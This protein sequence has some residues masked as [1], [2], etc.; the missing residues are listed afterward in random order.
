MSNSHLPE[1]RVAICFRRSVR[2]AR[3]LGNAKFVEKC[4]FTPASDRYSPYHRFAGNISMLTPDFAHDAMHLW[5]IRSKKTSSK[6]DK[7][8]SS[9]GISF[10]NP[11]ARR[12]A[13]ADRERLINDNAALLRSFAHLEM[14]SSKKKKR[15]G[16]R[17]TPGG[18]SYDLIDPNL[19]HDVPDPRE[20]YMQYVRTE[21]AHLCFRGVPRHVYETVGVPFDKLYQMV[22]Y[23]RNRRIDIGSITFKDACIY[24]GIDL[25][26][27]FDP[28]CPFGEGQ[29]AII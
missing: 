28:L 15:K 11:R 20:E 14:S 23:C 24:F 27:G 16:R 8:S 21:L 2:Y 12:I 25:G 18:Q 7:K 26:F 29:V 6:G 9:K 10:P 19:G 3:K 22:N 13:E 17:R 5:K 4:F 1:G